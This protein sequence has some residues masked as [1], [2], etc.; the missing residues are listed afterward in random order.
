MTHLLARFSL[1]ILDHHSIRHH[2]LSCCAK[3]PQNYRRDRLSS[4]RETI[5]APSLPLR[6]LKNYLS[7]AS[8]RCD[9]ISQVK[10]LAV[11]LFTSANS[12]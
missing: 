3:I 6:F 10:A 9:A 4:P 12:K 11:F 8:G 7:L 5:S 1:L 2:F